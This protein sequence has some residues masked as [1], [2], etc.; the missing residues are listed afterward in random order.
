MKMKSPAFK[1]NQMMPG[2]KVR[3]NGA[4]QPPRKSSVAM[5]GNARA[6]AVG[7]RRVGAERPAQAI[8][9]QDDG[10]PSGPASRTATI[11]KNGCAVDDEEM[12][13]GVRCLAVPI[14]NRRR[15]CVGTLSVSGPTTRLT[16][17]RVA[18]LAPS[19]RLVA[20]ETGKNRGLA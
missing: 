19:A 14:F 7:I 20:D 9:L 4:F 13:E 11:R 6:Q 17:E 15:Q 10:V 3:P 12:E 8:H 5:H 18:K 16:T 2:M 1:T